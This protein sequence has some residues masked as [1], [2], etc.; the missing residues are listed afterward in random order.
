MSSDIPPNQGSSKKT[1]WIVL[2]VVGALGIFCCLFS[3]VAITAIATLGSNANGT[4]Q[5]VATRV[6]PK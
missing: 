1:L 5:P 4:F 6:A 2:G 3:I